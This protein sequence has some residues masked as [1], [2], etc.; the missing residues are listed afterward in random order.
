M[1]FAFARPALFLLDPEDAHGLT[2]AV[3]KAMPSCARA[4]APVLATRVAGI[5]F[6][7]PVGLAAGFD[8]DAEVVDA[9]LSLGFGFV[10]V[11]TVTPRPQTGNDRPRL[12]RLGRDGGVI[13]RMGFNN[14]GLDAAC[15]RLGRRKHR[16]VV[17]ANVGANKDSADRI[18]DYVTGFSA[19]A[20]V[21]DY[22]TVNISSPNTPGLRG[23]Q[24]PGALTELLD[25]ITAVRAPGG[26]PLFLKLAPDLER[27]EIDAIVKASADK[28]DALLIGNTTLSR[29][30]LRSAGAGESGGLS[31]APL[32]SLAAAKLGEFR[33][34]AG[35]TVPL[36]AAGGIDSAAEA[37]ARIRAGASL[38]QLYSA[39]VYRGPRLASSISAGLAAMLARDGFSTLAEAVGVDAA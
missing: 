17:G 34:S 38:V 15:A 28:V 12:F 29:P 11:G 22:V 23:L 37:Y 21:A 2:I 18:A 19:M 20:R 9:M 13:N 36:I 24:D 27:R 10:E 6:P 32:R 16:G 3:L 4:F 14:K 39:L 33:A 7:S 1:L 30:P 35:R 25:A 8:K 31:G 5:D 26:P